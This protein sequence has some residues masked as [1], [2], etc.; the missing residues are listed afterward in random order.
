M[1]KANARSSHRQSIISDVQILRLRDVCTR[2][3]LCESLRT[4]SLNLVFGSHFSNV[5]HWGFSLQEPLRA[6]QARQLKCL[7]MIQQTIPDLK[8]IQAC[9]N[10]EEL[11]VVSCQMKLI[12]GLQNC[13]WL[14]KLLLY[15]NEISSIWGLANLKR[16]QVGFPWKRSILWFA[17]FHHDSWITRSYRWSKWSFFGN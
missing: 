16:L 15:G 9:S 13:I 7:K 3:D 1:K 10:L 5:I 12:D 8:G 14:E 6:E 11:W 4:G 2:W 17:S